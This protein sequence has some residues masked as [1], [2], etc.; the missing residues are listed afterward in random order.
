MKYETKGRMEWEDRIET[1]CMWEKGGRKVGIEKNKSMETS[2]KE[3]RKYQEN[4]NFGKYKIEK[5]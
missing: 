4:W 3:M 1:I 2:K 5:C